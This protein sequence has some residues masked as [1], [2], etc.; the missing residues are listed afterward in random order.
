MVKPNFMDS[1]RS[2]SSLSICTRLAGVSVS[3]LIKSKDTTLISGRQSLAPGV[4]LVSYSALWKMRLAHRLI[5]DHVVAPLQGLLI[6]QVVDGHALLSFLN[7]DF[8]LGF[9]DLV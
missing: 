4:S 7:L 3:I 5:I 1:I 9:S 8:L 2:S 6:P